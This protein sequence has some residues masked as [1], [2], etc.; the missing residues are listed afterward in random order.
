MNALELLEEV[1]PLSGMTSHAFIRVGLGVSR[2]AV[3]K[4]FRLDAEA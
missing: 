4:T 3:R 2:S 1:A